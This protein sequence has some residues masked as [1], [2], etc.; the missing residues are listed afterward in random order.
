MM[1]M[2]AATEKPA[3]RRRSSRIL[4]RVPLIINLLGESME[5]EWERV[6]TVTVSQHGGMVRTRQTFK[7]GSILEIR[8]CDK[9]RTARAR[10]AWTS[11]KLTPQGFELGFEI[12]DEE[13]FWEINFPPDRWSARKE[14]QPKQP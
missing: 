6:D 10:V 7:V 11:S 2:T 9:E 4:L 3:S 1:P 8:V 5:G 12:L 14:T 13:G